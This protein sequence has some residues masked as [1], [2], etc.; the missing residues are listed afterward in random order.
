MI[1]FT[2]KP[3]T[4]YPAGAVIAFETGDYSDFGYIG[5]VVTTRDCDFVALAEKYRENFVSNDEYHKP[6]P[7]GFVG[8]LTI[9]EFV[10][11]AT[12][13]TLHI[14]SYGRLEITQ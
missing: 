6:D 13:S 12:V 1:P 8:W 9:N 5:H 11:P 4:I 7:D 10:F 3:A 14:G 2:S